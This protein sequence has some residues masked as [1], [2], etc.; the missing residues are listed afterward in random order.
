MY[1]DI[2]W[3]G[4]INLLEQF[5][6][7]IWYPYIKNQVNVKKTMITSLTSNMGNFAYPVIFLYLIMARPLSIEYVW[8]RVNMIKCYII[9]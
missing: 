8:S 9:F 5:I 7:I 2:T 1:L 3:L 4:V 6:L